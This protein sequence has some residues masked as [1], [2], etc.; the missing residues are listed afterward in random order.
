[1]FWF[2][3]QTIVLFS[4][5]LYF[6]YNS[7]VQPH[8]NLFDDLAKER[9]DNAMAENINVEEAFEEYMNAGHS[10][11]WEQ[12]WEK[13]IGA[14]VKAI[15]L[16]RADP[17]AHN[18][19]GLALLQA[20]RLNDAL[21]V[22]SRAHQLAPDDPIPL[23]KSADILE[24]MGR[25]KDA[26]E[27]YLKVA[28]IYLGQHDLEKAI[29]N[30]E[31]A[32]RITPGL[33]RV[34]QRLAL[35]YERIGNRRQAVREYM[36]LAGN[37][38]RVGKTDVAIQAIERALRLEPRNPQALNALQALRSGAELITQLVDER[39]EAE[40]KKDQRQAFETAEEPTRDI[41]EA[42]PQGPIGEVV[43][44]ALS[45]LAEYIFSANI[46]MEPSGMNAIQAIELHRQ[47]SIESAIEAYHAAERAGLRNPAVY[48]GLGALMVEKGSWREAVVYLEKVVEEPE[49]AAGA[50]HGLGFAYMEMGKTREASKHLLQAMRT[51]DVG[52]AIDQDEEAQLGAIYVRLLQNVEQADAKTLDAMN[53]RFFELMTGEDWKQRVELTR[54][55]LEDAISEGAT[56]TLIDIA[57]VSPEILESMQLIEQFMHNRRFTLAMEEA[58]HVLQREPDYLAAHIRIGEILVQMGRV[59]QA[60]EKYNTIA[61]IYLARGNKA[62]AFEILNE[63][64]KVAPM[65]IRLRQNLIELLEE[66]G[67]EAEILEQYISMG[68]AYLDLAD[69]S[70]ARM[71]YNQAMQIAKRMEEGSEDKVIE[72][73]HKLADI[74]MSR[75][76]MRSAVRSYEE[77][78]RI[79]PTDVRARKNLIDLNYRLNDIGRAT[80]ELDELLQLFARQKRGAAILELLEEWVERRPNDEALRSRLGVVYQQIKRHN[81]ALEQF[82]ALLELQLQSGNHDSAC[83][84]IRRIMALKPADAQQY[85]D[86]FKQLGCA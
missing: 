85:V 79:A 72:I 39:L 75:L 15:E 74:D 13:A 55:Q 59:N 42:H 45:Q 19:L 54:H 73:L 38:Q 52:L 68:D 70:N 86:L 7:V 57:S 83:K 82:I 14:Y 60:I 44:T 22:Y 35:A 5:T 66:E 3:A 41:A 32:T 47:G 49:L 21:K 26:A 34:H 81:E 24:R 1:M 58:Y 46:M 12:D 2:K 48:M 40:E 84:T 10:Y 53:R 28:D 36:T 77:I 80:R 17:T 29:G 62:R 61:E 8:H 43:E 65:D 16:R 25:L 31:R 18:S 71:T 4:E 37:F 6:E 76:E 11:A 69:I 51:V 27:Q 30:W 33:V 67:R 20:R 56:D 23:E 9:A 78:R 50:N 64:V 63:V